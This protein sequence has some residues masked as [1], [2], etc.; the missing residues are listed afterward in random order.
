MA[1]HELRRNVAGDHA[2]CGAVRQET[3]PCGGWAVRNSPRHEPN[4]GGSVRSMRTA[5]VCGTVVN[6]NH[7]RTSTML[8]PLLAQSS[9][10]SV[11]LPYESIFIART[12]FSFFSPLERMVQFACSLLVHGR[13]ST[14]L[15]RSSANALSP[16]AQVTVC[17]RPEHIC[18]STISRLKLHQCSVVIPSP[19]DRDPTVYFSMLGRVMKYSNVYIFFNRLKAFLYCSVFTFHHSDD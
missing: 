7:A 1:G 19:L 16:L 18:Y 10:V 5:T 3:E 11:S 4:R 8:Q 17:A 6:T 14:M 13:H 9:L 15:R 12:S 2:V